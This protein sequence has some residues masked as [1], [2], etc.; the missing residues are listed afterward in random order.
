MKEEIGKKLVGL[1]LDCEVTGSQFVCGNVGGLVS[2]WPDGLLWETKLELEGEKVLDDS[3]TTSGYHILCPDNE[4][5]LCLGLL[6]SLVV[7]ETGGVAE[8]FEEAASTE[9]CTME[10][11]HMGSTEAG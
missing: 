6:Q 11:F 7:N 9:S 4:E 8:S 10:T 1:S 3:P 2:F 5:Y